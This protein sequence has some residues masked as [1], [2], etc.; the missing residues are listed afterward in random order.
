MQLS[1]TRR[2]FVDSKQ[3]DGADY[4]SDECPA[5][6]FEHFEIFK[7]AA[8]DVVDLPTFKNLAPG[9]RVSKDSAAELNCDTF[10]M[11]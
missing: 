7:M 4:E 5:G 3:F 10:G 2:F 6:N 11:I 8:F 9:A 1:G